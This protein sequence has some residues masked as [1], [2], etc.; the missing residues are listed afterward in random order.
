MF[1]TKQTRTTKVDMRKQNNKMKLLVL[2]LKIY[3]QKGTGNARHASRKAPHIC[4]WW[5][6][7]WPKR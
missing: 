5:C 2:H 7:T 3:A 6:C 1:Y 4:R